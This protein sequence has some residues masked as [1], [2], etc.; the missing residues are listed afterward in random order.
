MK[1][2]ICGI[3]IGI[4]LS[5]CVVIGYEHKYNLPIALN[6]QSKL[7]NK[8]KLSIHLIYDPHIEDKLKITRYN[9]A[10]NYDKLLKDM[11]EGKWEEE[12]YITFKDRKVVEDMRSLFLDYAEK[13]PARL[14]E[15]HK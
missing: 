10:Q 13:W 5:A 6:N 2:L 12:Y 15:I 1:N 7:N 4:I 8:G 11:D 3:T 9:I 14:V